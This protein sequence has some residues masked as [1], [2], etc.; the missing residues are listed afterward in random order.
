MSTFC[1]A[2][3]FL[4]GVMSLIEFVTGGNGSTQSAMC[5]ALWAMART[6]EIEVD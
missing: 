6:Y 4:F 3:S 2:M 1:Y 5:I